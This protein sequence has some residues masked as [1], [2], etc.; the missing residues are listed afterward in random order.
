M[1]QKK[2]Y[3]KIGYIVKFKFENQVKSRAKS[4]VTY[5]YYYL[6]WYTLKHFKSTK[7]YPYIYFQVSLTDRK[8]FEKMKTKIK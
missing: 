7:F 6:N 3:F 2:L 1:I 5:E 4:L 8:R